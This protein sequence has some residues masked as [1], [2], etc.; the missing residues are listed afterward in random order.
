[1]PIN[2][3]EFDLVGRYVNLGLSFTNGEFTKSNEILIWELMSTGCALGR[4]GFTYF[5]SCV[6][7]KC[8]WTSPNG[9][10]NRTGIVL[11]KHW[12]P[13][14]KQIPIT[15]LPS[16]SSIDVLRLGWSSKTPIHAH[17]GVL[18]RHPELFAKHDLDIELVSFQSGKTQ[19]KALADGTDAW[20]SQF[21]HSHVDS[22]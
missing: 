9:T 8:N 22:T 14:S 10:A 2:R 21:R 18:E 15:V 11:T 20:F 6:S 19:G 16:A 13:Q 17:I 1:M 4:N 5:G 12:C 3:K 7:S